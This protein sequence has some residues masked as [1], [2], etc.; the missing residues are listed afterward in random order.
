MRIH[1]INPNRL[2]AITR[3]LEDSARLVARPGTVVHAITGPGGPESVESHT[4]ELLGGLAVGRAVLQG[5]DE[6]ADAFVVACFGDT[7]VHAARELTTRPVVGMT[8]AAYYTAAMLAARFTV[9]T[10]P[11][12]T[13]EHAVRVLHETGLAHR[14]RVEA[15]EAAVV[16]LEDEAA[17]LLPMFLQRGRRA[18][19]E[20]SSEAIVLGCAGL[21][22]L[23]EPLR[24]ALG[25]PVIDGVLA[26]VTMAEGM[27]AAGL[28]TSGKSTYAHPGAA[29]VNGL[30]R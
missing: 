11:P 27:V 25:V 17:A 14:A 15:I 19:E 23:V 22:E 20:D 10:L 13:R 8:E 7:G 3:R 30:S 2:A 16:D 9:I 6:G 29:A 1:V 21:G 26:A 18:V 28:S 5:T 24:D 12:R 4:E